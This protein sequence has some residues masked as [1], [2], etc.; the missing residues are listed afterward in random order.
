MLITCKYGYNGF[1][2]ET[3]KQVEFEEL[4]KLIL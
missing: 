3:K 4:K 2:I 1:G